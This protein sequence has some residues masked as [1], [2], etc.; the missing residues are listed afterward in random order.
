MA[1]ITNGQKFALIRLA[2]ECGCESRDERLF[3]VSRLLCRGV[4]SFNE[5][6]RND[7]RQIRDAAHPH[8]GDGDWETVSAFR[9]QV[10]QI[11]QEFREQ[12]LGQLRLPA[13]G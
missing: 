7:W 12:V 13:T 8:W 5:L 3:V 6:D 9:L 1:E 2:K 11:L 4:G 10:A